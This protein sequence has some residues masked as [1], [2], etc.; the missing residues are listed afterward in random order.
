[1]KKLQSS[2]IVKARGRKRE[3]KNRKLSTGEKRAYK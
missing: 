3:R 1:M 2:Q